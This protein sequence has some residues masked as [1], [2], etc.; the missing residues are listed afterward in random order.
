VVT[1]H[2]RSLVADGDG[3]GRQAGSV[4][5]LL[6]LSGPGCISP[7]RPPKRRGRRHLESNQSR[8]DFFAADA[9]A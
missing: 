2:T 8:E 7:V 3:R 9:K 1:T 6:L 4:A 5:S